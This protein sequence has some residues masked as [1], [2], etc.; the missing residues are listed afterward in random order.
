MEAE[1]ESRRDRNRGVRVVG[2]K[3]ADGEA[4]ALR[5][6]S[7]IMVNLKA[8][9]R[10]ECHSCLLKAIFSTREWLIRASE[11]TCVIPC[12][13]MSVSLYKTTEGF[14]EYENHPFFACN[15]FTRYDLAR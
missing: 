12:D 6:V 14:I 7:R 1:V 8:S 4:D 11:Y 3:V 10:Q 9:E 13:V 15:H 5:L 2:R